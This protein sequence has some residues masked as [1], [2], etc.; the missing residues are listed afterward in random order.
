[1]TKREVKS[2]VENTT[3]SENL[4]LFQ[5]LQVIADDEMTY[6]DKDTTAVKQKQ[7]SPDEICM[8]PFAV[9]AL[10]GKFTDSFLDTESSS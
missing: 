3:L 6:S 4:S 2:E 5:S 8:K 7:E 9:G 10:I 1:M